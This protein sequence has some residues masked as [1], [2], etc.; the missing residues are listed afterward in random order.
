M[1]DLFALGMESSVTT[2]ED[3]KETRLLASFV[4]GSVDCSYAK[5]S[6]YR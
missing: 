1:E 6:S 2:L 5:R 4:A 3:D